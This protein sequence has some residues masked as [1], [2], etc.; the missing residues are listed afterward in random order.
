MSFVEERTVTYAFSIARRQNSGVQHLEPKAAGEIHHIEAFPL[1]R[2]ALTLQGPS[3]LLS[4]SLTNPRNG[5]RVVSITKT[6]SDAL[7]TT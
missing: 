6:A 3:P 7:R 5:L 4:C 1:G 2:V